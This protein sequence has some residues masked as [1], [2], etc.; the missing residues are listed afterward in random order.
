MSLIDPDDPAYEWKVAQSFQESVS[1]KR[2]DDDEPVHLTRLQMFK[3]AAITGAV[4]SGHDLYRDALNDISRF[5]QCVIAEAPGNEHIATSMSAA[6]AWAKI[7]EYPW[8]RPGKP[9]PQAQ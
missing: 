2:P 6:D 9:R 3:I 8:P 5:L 7:D 4:H 1:A